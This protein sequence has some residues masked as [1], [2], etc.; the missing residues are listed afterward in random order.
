MFSAADTSLLACSS[1]GLQ[2]RWTHR[3]EGLCS[4]QCSARLRT[5]KEAAPNRDCLL[6]KLHSWECLEL[7]DHPQVPEPPDVIIETTGVADGVTKV[8][9]SRVWGRLIED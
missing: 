3:P 8:D 9:A 4:E 7:L 2:T 1:G 5:A 6:V